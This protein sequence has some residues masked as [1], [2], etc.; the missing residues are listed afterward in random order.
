MMIYVYQ[1]INVNHLVGSSLANKIW[2]DIE[3]FLQWEWRQHA[4]QYIYI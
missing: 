2:I 1:K 4:Q 3:F